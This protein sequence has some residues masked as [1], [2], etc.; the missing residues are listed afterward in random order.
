MPEY[1]RGL[2]ESGIEMTSQGG[3]GR[4]MSSS[5][6]SQGGGPFDDGERTP[7]GGMQRKGSL[8]QGLKKRIGSL[9][10]HMH[11]PGPKDE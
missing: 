9:K 2:G 11:S 10:K 7:T 3:N 6:L 8:S 4:Q 1:R 5:Q